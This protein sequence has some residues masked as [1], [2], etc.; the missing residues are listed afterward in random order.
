[1]AGAASLY[2]SLGGAAGV[3]QLANAFGVDLANN[4]VVS[5]LLGASGIEAAKTGLSNS[6]A[7]AANMAVP[8]GSPDLLGALSG[9]GLDASA[10]QGVASSLMN[11]AKS[12]GLKPD[13]MAALTSLWE[14]IGKS[15]L[16][17]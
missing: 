15:L 6:I 4:S 1:M 12:Q 3:T 9:K 11:A 5:A 14:P 10:V 17:G 7:K 8:A 16:G 2:S 13:Q